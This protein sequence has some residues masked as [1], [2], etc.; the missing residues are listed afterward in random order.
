MHFP[1]ER[2]VFAV[3]FVAVNRLPYRTLSDSYFPDWIDA[4][5]NVENIDFDILVTA[6]G[7]NGVK[8]DV[9][10]HRN[11]LEDLY[12]AVLKGARAGESLEQMESNITL[13]TYKDWG[14]Y[15]EWRPLNIQGMYRQ[16]L[17][18]RRGN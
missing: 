11:Y 3:D 17:L 8:Q 13:D 7:P 5:K 4:L 18:H 16:I 12:A 9:T 1:E 6:H 10:A 15:D 2:A 14:R